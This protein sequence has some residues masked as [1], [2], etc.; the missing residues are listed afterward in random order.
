MA[1]SPISDIGE[2]MRAYWQAAVRRN[3]APRNDPAEEPTRPS[4]RAREEAD[5]ERARARREAR[6]PR[7]PEVGNRFDRYA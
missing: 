3:E 4:R 1:V 6:A 7:H 5:A 2:Q